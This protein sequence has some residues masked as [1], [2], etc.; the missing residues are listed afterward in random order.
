[1]ILGLKNFIGRGT[2]MSNEFSVTVDKT[3]TPARRLI[4][5]GRI[6]I[7][8]ADIL[9]HKLSED[10]RKG[11]THFVLNMRQVSMLTSSGIRTLL[12]F[13][14]KAKQCG[15]SFYVQDPSENVI[16]VLGMTALDEM[17]IK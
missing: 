3:Y 7:V 17:L 1:L 5:R 16:N 4:L 15:G 12:A 6:T 14:K 2:Y 13:Y 10:F 11:Y 8:N 9:H